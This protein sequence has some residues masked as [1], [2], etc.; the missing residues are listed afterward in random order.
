MCTGAEIAYLA[1]V[2]VGTGYSMYA[3]DTAANQEEANAKAAAEQANA[4]ANAAAGEAQ[5]EA[6]RIR[7]EGKRLRAQAVA[8]AAAA[9]VDVDSPTALR[10]D[11]AVTAANEED[12]MLT[13]MQGQDRS[14]RLRQ[15][16]QADTIAAGNAATAGRMNQTATLIGG[17]T[18]AAS[19][20]GD[21]WKRAKQN[22]GS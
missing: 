14:A 20:G 11:Q 8:N 2:A 4:D 7:K 1:V 18:K 22:G 13:L 9:G 17:A 16:G 10:I 6:D 12:A 15:Q 21:A 19:Y 5:V 3:T